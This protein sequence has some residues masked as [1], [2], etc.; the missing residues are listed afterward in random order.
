MYRVQYNVLQ[1]VVQYNV[2]RVLQDNYDL[3]VLYLEK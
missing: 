1:T 2:L 3:N